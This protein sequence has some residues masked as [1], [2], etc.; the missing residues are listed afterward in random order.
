MLLSLSARINH[1]AVGNAVHCAI[2]LHISRP[3]YRSPVC[4]FNSVPFFSPPL[5]GAKLRQHCA[6]L[7]LNDALDSLASEEQGVYIAVLGAF[8]SGVSVRK[9]FYLCVLDSV[10]CICCAMLFVVWFYERFCPRHLSFRTR[11]SCSTRRHVCAYVCACCHLC[12]ACHHFC[13]ACASV[14]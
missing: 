4:P 11:Y 13:S 5:Q 9:H 14:L 10:P 8:S 7:A 1:A 2:C 12:F 6:E 3:H